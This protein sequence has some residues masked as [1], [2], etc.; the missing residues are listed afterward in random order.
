MSSKLQVY[1]YPPAKNNT[2]VFPYFALASRRL[3]MKFK[4]NVYTK[5]ANSMVG[6]NPSSLYGSA[7]SLLFM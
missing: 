1:L 6:I 3:R 7:L 4:Y 5:C 2:I